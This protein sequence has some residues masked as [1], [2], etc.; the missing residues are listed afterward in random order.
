M[1]PHRFAHSLARRIRAIAVV[2][3]KEHNRKGRRLSHSK[4]NTQGATRCLQYAP[5]IF[6]SLKFSVMHR[7][8][9]VCYAAP[10]QLTYTHPF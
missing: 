8:G 6:G 2:T 7:G 10:T 1:L 3:D 5:S 9:A 4:P